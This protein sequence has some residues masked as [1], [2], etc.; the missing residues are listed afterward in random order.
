MHLVQ[1]ESQIDRE[2][3]FG[4][5]IVELDRQVHAREVKEAQRVWVGSRRRLAGT[6]FDEDF[7]HQ[8]RENRDLL[9]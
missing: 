2:H 4:G 9:D 7:V 6:G 3:V 5:E 8:L 1:N